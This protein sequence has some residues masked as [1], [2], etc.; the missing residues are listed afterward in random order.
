MAKRQKQVYKV[1]EITPNIT[2]EENERRVQE[3]WNV[4]RQIVK[5]RKEK[6]K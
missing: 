2:E 5:E 6:G 3:F 1:I 4:I